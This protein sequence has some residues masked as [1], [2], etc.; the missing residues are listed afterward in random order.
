MSACVPNR[1]CERKVSEYLPLFNRTLF[2]T[3]YD[4]EDKYKHKI[5]DIAHLSI[6]CNAHIEYFC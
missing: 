4:T 2:V 5:F 1:Y 6:Q 3:S